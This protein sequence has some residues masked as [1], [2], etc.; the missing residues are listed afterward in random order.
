MGGVTQI[1]SLPWAHKGV[2]TRHSVARQHP[3]PGHGRPAVWA[4]RPGRALHKGV[5]TASA[6]GG[7]SA[8]ICTHV[9]TLAERATY[10]KQIKT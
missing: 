6:Q 9:N 5:E 4:D 2:F 10:K 1:T 3:A 7:V 8:V